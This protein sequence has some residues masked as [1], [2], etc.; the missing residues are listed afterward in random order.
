MLGDGFE[1]CSGFQLNVAGRIYAGTPIL[2]HLNDNANTMGWVS[3][4]TTAHK[5]SEDTLN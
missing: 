1:E 5:P 3:S 4:V 2:V